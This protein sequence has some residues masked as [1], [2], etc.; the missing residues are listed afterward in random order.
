MAHHPTDRDRDSI[1]F[2]PAMVRAFSGRGAVSLRDRS[3]T[4]IQWLQFPPVELPQFRFDLRFTD[5]TTDCDIT[6]DAVE[7]WDLQART[8]AAYH[9][10][11]L[12]WGDEA[13]RLPAEEM[14]PVRSLVPQASRWAPNLL[15]RNGTFHKR[16]VDPDGVLRLTSFALTSEVQCDPE[17]DLVRLRLTVR[18]RTDAPLRLAVTPN[19]RVADPVVVSYPVVDRASHP[20]WNELGFDATAEDFPAWGRRQA[21]TVTARCD[22]PEDGQQWLLELPPRATGSHEVVL[23]IAAPAST[24]GS[25]ELAAREAG[26]AG[27]ESWD[28]ARRIYLARRRAVF[29]SLP[30]LTAGDQRLTAFYE[31][32]IATVVEST[33]QREN[34]ILDPFYSAGTWLFALAWDISF[35]ARAL[36]L[37][38]PDAVRRTLL[39]LV[40]RGLGEHSYIG[41][42]GSLG[43]HY[44]YSLIAGVQA[45]R[46]YLEVTG[47]ASVLDAPLPASGVPLGRRLADDLAAAHAA[48]LR[49]DGL[50]DYG[51]TTHHFL[52][53]RTD[54]YQG[55][56]AA[57]TVQTADA[58]AWL[59]GQGWPCLSPAQIAALRQA[60]EGLWDADAQWYATAP[61]AGRH[62]LVWSYQVLELLSSESLADERKAA[63]ASHLVPGRFLARH[64]LY[65]IARTDELHWDHDDADW[66]GGGQYTGMPLRIAEA[67]WRA[68]LP[69]DAWR[70]LSRC[71]GWT[72]AFGSIPQEIMG[73]SLTTLDIEQA[74]EIAVG[75]GIQA[76]IFGLFGIRPRPD[77]RLVVAPARPATAAPLGLHG[78]R[79]RGRLL[80]VE[81]GADTWRAVWDGV[82]HSL[83][84]GEVLNLPAPS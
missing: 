76:V 59:A 43:H 72:E 46:D 70:V 75:A 56:T 62:E 39:A 61:E 28:R 5:L 78:Y 57:I 8:V 40:D 77:G 55:A 36:S 52:E 47:D 42:D 24:T 18:N 66:G 54:D 44:S 27:P 53:N 73:D 33:W 2:P 4:G 79:H 15:V 25:P 67:L 23:A 65:S 7:L 50:L 30:T 74:A 6:D 22:L 37:V 38:D 26:T 21:F 69:G 83:T 3:V 71:L 64:G 49:S 9:P 45:I 84:Y 19:L 80:D 29:D 17:H 20:R 13:R 51:P 81:L 1:A 60:G 41:W 32:C 63:L 58:A 48:R 82:D 12:N 14:R 10:L 68:G 34:F 31:A 16:L 11:A 35:A